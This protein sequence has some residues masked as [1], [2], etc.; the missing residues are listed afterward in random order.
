MTAQPARVLEIGYRRGDR[1]GMAGPGLWLLVAMDAGDPVLGR[2]WRLLCEGR[3]GDVISALRSTD[4][5]FVRAFAV[6]YAGPEGTWFAARGDAQA[7]ARLADGERVE[8]DGAYGG[9]AERAVGGL[10]AGLRLSAGAAAAGSDDV[11][12]PLAAGLVLA[13]QLGTREDVLAGSGPQAAG[14]DSRRVPPAPSHSAVSQPSAAGVAPAAPPPPSAGT[15]GPPPSPQ[16]PVPHRPADEDAAKAQDADAGARHFFVGRSGVRLVGRT[17]GT[18]ALAAAIPPAPARQ[19]AVPSVIP[20]KAAAQPEPEPATEARQPTVQPGTGRMREVDRPGPDSAII[21]DL[22]LPGARPG[23]APPPPSPSP[24][25]IPAPPAALSPPPI[26]E[27]HGQ[28]ALADEFEG[29]SSA[30]VMQ[31]PGAGARPGALPAAGART[32]IAVRCPAGHPNPQSAAACRVCRRGIEPQ[33][34]VAVAQPALGVLRLSTGDAVTLDRAVF[35]GRDPRLTDEQK[36]GRPHILRLPGPGS[37]I[38]R[39]HLEVRVLGWLVA[40][41]DLGSTNHTTII[42]PGGQEERLIAG[43]PRVIEPGTQVGLAAVV[44]FVYEAG[45]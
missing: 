15:I 18:E 45:G 42:A 26:P 41:V 34:P 33:E 40:L 25:P 44:W 29:E 43:V 23:V 9:V 37:D 13:S 14:A 28:P 20:D 5:E 32:V 17:D 39:T 16:S 19:A 7:C 31:T 3:T 12:L 6:A 4:A 30:T 38:S 2:W 10:L 22:G 36:S 1:V 8:V 21:W 35:L 24:P 11:F 27:L